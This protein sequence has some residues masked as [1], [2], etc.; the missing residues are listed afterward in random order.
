MYAL[1][2]LFFLYFPLFFPSL[3]SKHSPG[4]AG[5]APISSLSAALVMKIDQSHPKGA[6]VVSSLLIPKISEGYVSVVFCA[7]MF[8]S[9]PFWNFFSG[10]LGNFYVLHPRFYCIVTSVVPPTP[11]NSQGSGFSKFHLW[12]DF[13]PGLGGCRKLSGFP[14]DL[15]FKVAP[16]VDVLQENNPAGPTDLRGGNPQSCPLVALLGGSGKWVIFFCDPA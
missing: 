16:P 14:P 9:L 15:F 2:F 13:F 3:A 7:Q 6:L 5:Y 4:L 11:V 1:K 8:C 10:V 12:L